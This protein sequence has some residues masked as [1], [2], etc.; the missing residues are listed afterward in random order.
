M[1][2]TDLN[3]KDLF[4]VDR[5]SD[6]AIRKDK[7]ENTKT[8]AKLK[9][10]LAKKS[11]LIRW[12][13]VAD[14]LAE[15]AVEALDIPVMKL[16]LPAWRKYR[17]IMEYGD[18]EKHPPDETSL[19]SLADHTV[20][21][22]YE[23]DLQVSYLG[24]ELSKLKFTLDAELTLQGIVLRIRDGKI[25]EIK[26][27]TVNGKGTLLLEKET[28]VEKP[29]GSYNLPGSVDLGDG[30]SLRDPGAEHASTAAGQ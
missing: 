2:G 11:K 17:E 30:I 10:D 3:M 13:A 27:G 6:A 5:K 23:E 1:S 9:E 16:L 22:G 7:F 21:T 29:F 25:K 26:A 12:D 15:K 4:G 28:V 20:K 18:P 24:V 8:A 19:V 14:V